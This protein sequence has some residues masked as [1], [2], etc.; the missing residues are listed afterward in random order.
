MIMRFLMTLFALLMLAPAQALTVEEIG[1]GAERLLK[2]G[3]FDEL[4]RLA[5][6][7]IRQ[8]T[9]L[10]AGNSALY[11]FYDALGGFKD[12]HNLGFVSVIPRAKRMNC[13][14]AG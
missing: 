13:C 6:E 8:D 2:E 7:Y 10:V 11:H 14:R 1:G 9:R 4:D 5:S 12:S 3:R